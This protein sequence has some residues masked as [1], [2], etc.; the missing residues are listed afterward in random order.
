MEKN[1][2]Y[3]QPQYVNK[4]KCDGSKCNAH[5]CGRWS[6]FIDENTFRQYPPEI[7]A[8]MQFNSD[9]KE[10]RIV[11]DE[12]DSC[13]FLNENKLCGIQLK[14]GE[15]FLS[16]T[17]ATYPR[18]TNYF[19]YFFERALALSCPVAAEIIFKERRMLS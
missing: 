17:C 11:L 19:G 6:I 15:S 4:F 10:Y 14:Y 16:Q 12:N 9:K 8:H 7:T 2:F 3:F 5:C 18:I 1:Y 13:P